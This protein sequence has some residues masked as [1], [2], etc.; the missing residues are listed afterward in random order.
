[1]KIKNFKDLSKKESRDILKIRNHYKIRKYMYN[2]KKIS[3]KEHK[4]FLKYLKKSKDS[5]FIIKIDGKIAGSFNI[6]NGYL[7]LYKN[8]NLR[9]F[10]KIILK[11]ALN[12]AK[13]M[14]FKKVYLEVFRSNKKAVSLYKKEGFREIKKRWA[15]GRRILV[16]ERLQ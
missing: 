16:F 8:P 14:G 13:E 1:M 11:T 3:Y 7:G 9:G 5:Y 10:G 6:K 4:K 2:N 12:L 15:N